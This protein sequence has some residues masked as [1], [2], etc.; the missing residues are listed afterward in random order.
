MSLVSFTCAASSHAASLSI[1]ACLGRTFQP[2]Q[3]GV[4]GHLSECLLL[5]HVP[6]PGTAAN[7]LAARTDRAP[8]APYLA[9]LAFL[10]SPALQ[11]F[12]VSAA[13][14]LDAVAAAARTHPQQR[15]ADPGARP[16][17]RAYCA[18]AAANLAVAHRM[19]ATPEAAG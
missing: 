2:L 1:A 11:A 16:R 12:L 17:G 14:P 13:A 19:A 9:F 5:I 18:P 7:C 6:R 3:V 15:S 8:A 10:A 4:T